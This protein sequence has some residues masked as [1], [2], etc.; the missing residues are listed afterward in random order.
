LAS[1]VRGDSTKEAPAGVDIE[2]A[3][4]I[5]NKLGLVSDD[6]LKLGAEL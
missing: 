1:S 6:S 3:F 4:D 5:K 2:A